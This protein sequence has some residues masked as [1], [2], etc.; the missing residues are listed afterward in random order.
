M[1]ENR[2]GSSRYGDVVLQQTNRADK[3]WA[4]A[5]LS[6]SLWLFFTALGCLYESGFG[7][8]DHDWSFTHKISLFNLPFS[9]SD[10]WFT[11]A[12]Y[13]GVCAL[14]AWLF[15]SN[16]RKPLF[17]VLGYVY[18]LLSLSGFNN[19]ISYMKELPEQDP[20]PS[21]SLGLVLTLLVALGCFLAYCGAGLLTPPPD[22]ENV[23]LTWKQR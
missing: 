17:V 2:Q 10:L 5:S 21:L 4:Y 15:G 18:G 16:V 20:L 7:R 13:F 11:A 9:T 12:I 8:G 14:L 3:F 6:L 22:K 1:T 23:K 19:A